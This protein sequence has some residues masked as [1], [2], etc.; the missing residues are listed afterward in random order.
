MTEFQS[1]FLQYTNCILLIYKLYTFD[2]HSIYVRYTTCIRRRKT[3][4]YFGIFR[5][6]NNENPPQRWFIRGFFI[7]GRLIKTRFTLSPCTYSSMINICPCVCRWSFFAMGSCDGSSFLP[8]QI[9]ARQPFVPFLSWRR[10]ST[11]I[12]SSLNPKLDFPF[13]CRIYFLLLCGCDAFEGKMLRIKM[14]CPY[15]IVIQFGS[16]FKSVIVSVSI[17]FAFVVKV[18]LT[19]KWISFIL[20]FA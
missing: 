16:V 14:A 9:C 11:G 8:V 15:V 4:C 3:R 6:R 12:K 20:I 17:L 2:I 18:G 7:R 19:W 5:Y 13:F 1:V 10:N